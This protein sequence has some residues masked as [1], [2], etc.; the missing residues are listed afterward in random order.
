MAG[1]YYA[2]VAIVGHYGLLAG[3][4]SFVIA[5]VAGQALSARLLFAEDLGPRARRIAVVVLV[6]MTLAFS[7]FTY[8]PPRLFLFEHA[9]TGHYGIF[10]EGDTH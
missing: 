5:I 1:G 2:Y 4:G 10:D 8:R 6:L 3:I 9:G 7:T